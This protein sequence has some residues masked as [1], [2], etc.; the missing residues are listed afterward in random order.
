MPSFP[1]RERLVP[2]VLLD[3]L[4]YAPE[5]ATEWLE[6]ISA[7]EVRVTTGVA[8]RALR[9]KISNFREALFWLEDQGL[10]LKVSQERKRGTLIVRLKQPTNI[11]VAE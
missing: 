8:S 3:Y 4:L 11:K 7:D 5:D 6:C 1:I 10:V 2:H 9:M